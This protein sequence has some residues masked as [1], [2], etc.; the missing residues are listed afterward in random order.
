VKTRTDILDEIHKTL[1]HS[2][3]RNVF[4]IDDQR[5]VFQEEVIQ[6]F[7]NERSERSIGQRFIIEIQMNKR[8]TQRI[9]T[10]PID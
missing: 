7:R 8:S 3:E 10:L 2:I 9:K 1:I 6:I 5:I 4:T